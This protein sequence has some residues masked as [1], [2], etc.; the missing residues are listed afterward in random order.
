MFSEPAF[1]C[2]PVRLAVNL[3]TRAGLIVI[4][5]MTHIYNQSGKFFPL[6]RNITIEGPSQVFYFFYFSLATLHLVHDPLPTLMVSPRTM[7]M[8]PL[9]MFFD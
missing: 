6:I 7:S 5:L 1:V 8:G 2:V 4:K 3:P 9:R